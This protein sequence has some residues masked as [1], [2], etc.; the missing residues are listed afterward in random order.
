MSFS[1]NCNQLRM[2]SC[3]LGKL[4]S[5]FFV[6]TLRRLAQRKIIYT[7]SINK[8][9]QKVNKRY[10]LIDFFIKLT[11]KKMVTYVLPPNSTTSILQIFEQF[12]G[13]PMILF[14]VFVKMSFLLSCHFDLITFPTIY[15]VHKMITL[16]CCQHYERTMIND[17]K[18]I[19]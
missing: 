18:S 17:N 6:F 12:S 14:W 3:Y 8:Q 4:Y 1:C 13:R 5:V 19:N 10:N 15:P 2:K 7:N 16:L 11:K 9:N